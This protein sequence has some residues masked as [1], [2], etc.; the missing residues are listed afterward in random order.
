LNYIKKFEDVADKFLYKKY[1]IPKKFTDFEKKYKSYLLSKNEE[2]IICK[3]DF[4][5]IEFKII[6]NPSNL[7]NI[8]SW[9]RGIIDKKGN[10]YVEETVK[11]LH[12]IIIEC[13]YDMGYIEDEDDLWHLELPKNFITIQRYNGSNEFYLGES[14][15]TMSLKRKEK[16]PDRYSH[17]PPHEEVKNEFQKFLDKAKLKNPK[18]EF[19]NELIVD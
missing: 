17:L 12:T 16:Y 13:L 10:L 9:V 4:L 19:L 18:Y 8:G 14:N 1:K 2:I 15:E 3:S 5:K 6:K 11:S 7:K